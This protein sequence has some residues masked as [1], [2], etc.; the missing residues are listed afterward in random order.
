LATLSTP[1][2][3]YPRAKEIFEQLVSRQP[4][5]EAAKHKLDG[6]SG[7]W[8]F[9]RLTRRLP[10]RSKRFRR[11]SSNLT[12]PKFA[13]TSRSATSNPIRA[14]QAAPPFPLSWK[15][16]S[17]TTPKIHFAVA[18]RRR[19]LR[20]LRS[21]SEKPSACSEAILRRAPEHTPTLEKLLDF[22]LGAG[23]DRRTAELAAQLERIH[24][25]RGDSAGADRFGE[26]ARRF[27]RRCGPFPTQ[28]FWLLVP[29]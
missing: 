25:E 20:Q 12:A 17:T 22:V 21:Y 23:D 26:L 9:F 6:V 7:K 11:N 3:K 1:P 15:S 13:A 28:I 14:L 5:S 16:R 8:A 4:E 2:G 24:T 27:Q 29:L 19:P 10:S 18:H